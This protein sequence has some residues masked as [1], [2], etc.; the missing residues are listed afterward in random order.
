MQI[1]V[2]SRRKSAPLLGFILLFDSSKLNAG[3]IKSSCQSYITSQSNQIFGLWSIC[4]TLSRID[5]NELVGSSNEVRRVSAPGPRRWCTRAERRRGQCRHRMQRATGSRAHGSTDP[6][7]CP[8]CSRFCAVAAVA[9]MLLLPVSTSALPLLV[10]G[11]CTS[12]ASVQCRFAT[13]G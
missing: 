6:P 3:C 7:S 4:L 11:P 1:A 12:P 13:P 10:R 2:K 8:P 9:C 5:C